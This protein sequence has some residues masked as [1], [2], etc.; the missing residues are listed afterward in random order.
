MISKTFGVYLIWNIKT[1]KMYVGST[2]RCFSDRWSRHRSGLRSKTHANPKLQAAWNKYGE[3]AFVFLVFQVC[4]DKDSVIA[5]EQRAIDSFDAVNKG[6]NVLPSA[7]SSRGVKRTPELRQK[8]K[9]KAND[10]AAKE[11]NR[12]RNVATH[13]QPHM[14]EAA[15]SR[16]KNQM[17]SG[18]ARELLLTSMRQYFWSM[19]GIS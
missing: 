16:A 6:Y 1:H 7:E 18:P 8:L 2:S 5:S 10:P 13:R 12:Q 17:S 14:R 11:K 19:E 9:A 3:S 4:S 15:R